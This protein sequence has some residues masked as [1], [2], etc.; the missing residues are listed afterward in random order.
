MPIQP[1]AAPRPRL[2]LDCFIAWSVGKACKDR[3]G[4]ALPRTLSRPPQMLVLARHFHREHTL[5]D[6]HKAR[7]PALVCP[8]P[9]SIRPLV[10]IG[11]LRT[12]IVR[13]A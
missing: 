1:V 2:A 6:H 7:P 10:A 4:A 3:R 8:D 5:A 12:P 13:H 9:T 11:H